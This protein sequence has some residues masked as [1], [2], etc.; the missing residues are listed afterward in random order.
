MPTSSRGSAGNELGP[1]ERRDRS[2]LG[3]RRRRAEAAEGRVGQVASGVVGRKDAEAARGLGRRLLRHG[4]R[5]SPSV[6]DLC[7]DL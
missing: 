5:G 6:A 3:R 2:P 1:T 7:V 4:A